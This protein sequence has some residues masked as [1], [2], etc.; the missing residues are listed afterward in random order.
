MAKASKSNTSDTDNV[1][2]SGAEDLAALRAEL[3]ELRT[4]KAHAEAE[5][6]TAKGA[7]RTAELS[8]M[9]ADERAIVSEQEACDGRLEAAESAASAIES[10][11]AQLADEP[12]HGADIAKLTRQLSTLSVKIEA[13]T[14]RKDYLAAQREKVTTHNK[15]QRE[16]APA[17]DNG[18]KLANGILLSNLGAP[19]QAWLEAR[20][21][22]FTDVRYAKLAVLAAQKAVD[23]EGL[24]DQSPEYFR[25]IEKELGEGP[26]IAS[27]DVEDDVEDG[28]DI[29]AQD[30]PA[31]QTESYAPERP[32]HRAAG[33]GSMSN[34]APPTRQAPAGG[35]GGR[36]RAPTLTAEERE[37]ALSLYP[38]S[39]LSD[40][41]KLV[42]Y[43]A[44]KKFMADRQNQ[45]LRSN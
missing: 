22:A 18:R 42:R 25:F 17:D 38:D 40:A 11:I 33:P 24:Q 21:K 1:A 37:V 45:V 8:R 36:Q 31:R 14:G 9:S 35:G 6:R 44:G 13:E 4:G 12:G 27:A 28:D 3:A 16:A 10:Q 34:V 7:L 32:Q 39:K 20:P 41:D 26:A 5:A 2:D 29:L 30:P 43:A 19:T 15:Q 23:V